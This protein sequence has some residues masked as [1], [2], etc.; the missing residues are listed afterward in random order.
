MN[1]NP[2]QKIG[3]K[4]RREIVL[5]VLRST[6]EGNIATYESLGDILESHDRRI[7]QSAVNSAKPALEKLHHK[8]VTAIPDVGY[9]VVCANEHLELARVHQKKSYRQLTKS[10]SKVVHVDLSGLTDGERTAITLAA[11][12]ISLQLDYMRRN[13]IRASRIEAVVDTVMST[14]ARSQEEIAKLRARL[15]KLESN[16]V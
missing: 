15:E 2:F 6:N 1:L 5:D 12:S 16:I 13:D 4:S 14:Q 11:T 7:I 8:A 3:E 9:R 10:K